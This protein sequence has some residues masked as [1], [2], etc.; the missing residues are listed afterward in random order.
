M[1]L[2]VKAKADGVPSSSTPTCSTRRA[3]VQRRVSR[4]GAILKSISKVTSSKNGTTE[5]C[6]V[7]DVRG[8]GDEIPC[9]DW[10]Q[11]HAMWSSCVNASSPSFRNDVRD[12]SNWRDIYRRAAPGEEGGQVQL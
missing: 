4:E 2:L 3:E 9:A 8:E 1:G 6:V 7:K 5:T 11:K 12:T 10:E